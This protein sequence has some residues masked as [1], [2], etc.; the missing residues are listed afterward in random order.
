MSIHRVTGCSNKKRKPLIYDPKTLDCFDGFKHFKA[1]KQQISEWSILR[2][3]KSQYVPVKKEPNDSFEIAYNN[4]VELADQLICYSDNQINLYKTG[5]IE[6]ARM[7]YFFKLFNKTAID[8][9]PITAEETRW[10][11]LCDHGQLY[12]KDKN[13]E[14]KAYS[15]DIN[16]MYMAMMSS[17]NFKMPI[18]P[19]TLKK[20]SVGDFEKLQ[21]HFFECGIYRVKIQSDRS[22]NTAKCS[23][24]IVII[25]IRQ[26]TSILLKNLV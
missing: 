22:V 9:E 11:N 16:S 1:T 10:I 13:Y 2:S 17:V 6:R 12:Y 3:Y 25:I 8:I 18:K 5:T 23:D 24:L 15:Y 21:T 26:L 7:S 14:G 19:G 4:F 20:L